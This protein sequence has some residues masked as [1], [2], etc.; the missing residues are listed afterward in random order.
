MLCMQLVYVCMYVYIYNYTCM[1]MCTYA[2]ACISPS[3]HA[4]LEHPMGPTALNFVKDMSM[5]G[6]SNLS[7]CKIYSSIGRNVKAACLTCTV[8]TCT[9]NFLVV[10]VKSVFHSCF[11][12]FSQYGMVHTLWDEEETASNRRSWGWKHGSSTQMSC[13]IIKT[14]PLEWPNH[15]RGIGIPLVIIHL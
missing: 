12:F 5:F 15:G 13:V 3:I 6:A 14:L 2:Q 1:C 7:Y 11:F 10:T 9:I 4:E 8:F